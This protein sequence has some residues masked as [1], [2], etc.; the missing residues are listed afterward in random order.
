MK[1]PKSFRR[2]ENKITGLSDVSEGQ[3][4]RCEHDAISI[5][6]RPRPFS[7]FLFP[8]VLTQAPLD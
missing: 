2:R 3:L 8:V 5:H 7:I 6:Y 1:S 4:V